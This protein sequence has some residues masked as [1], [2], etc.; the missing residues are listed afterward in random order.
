MSVV[1][2]SLGRRTTP[3]VTWALA[4]SD[5]GCP[6]GM[7]L[8]GVMA[9]FNVKGWSRSLAATAILRCAFKAPEFFK[10]GFGVA[11][12]YVWE[13]GASCNVVGAGIA[14]KAAHA[15]ALS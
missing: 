10:V 6:G 12:C 9:V 2:K 8:A 15:L 3:S 7:A 11:V 1:G 5:V 13:T 4:S 14:N